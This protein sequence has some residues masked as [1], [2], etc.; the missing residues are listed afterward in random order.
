MGGGGEGGEHEGSIFQ[1]RR[2]QLEDGFVAAGGALLEGRLGGAEGVL[3]ECVLFVGGGSGGGG[4][5]GDL[6]QPGSQ[7]LKKK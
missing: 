7:V 5:R 1:E 2:D 4:G 3:G 6:A